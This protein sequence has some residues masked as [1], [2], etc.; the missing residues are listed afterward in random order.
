MERIAPHAPLGMVLFSSCLVLDGHP[1]Y[2]IAFPGNPVRR[3]RDDPSGFWTSFAAILQ[4]PCQTMTVVHIGSQCRDAALAH[5]ALTPA[6]QEASR[7]FGRG[8][9][10]IQ[11]PLQGQ[12]VVAVPGVGSVSRR[13]LGGL[14][15]GELL[16]QLS[17]EKVPR[18]RR[19]YTVILAEILAAPTQEIGSG[20]R[21][22][23]PSLPG[24][25]VAPRRHGRLRSSLQPLLMRQ[26]AVTV[27]E[28]PQLTFPCP[29]ACPGS[30]SGS[31]QAH[32]SLR[33]PTGPGA[34]GTARS[35]AASY[36]AAVALATGP[37]DSCVNMSV[38]SSLLR[39]GAVAE[40]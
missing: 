14:G 20:I 29:V 24:A 4:D 18:F 1:P 17:A 19:G 2:V 34:G 32:A 26:L 28:S 27:G 23:N 8:T 7:A 40:S 36:R 22:L 6:V 35:Q 15:Q 31:L 10:R 30:A 3:S 25:I 5:G 33:R 39:R 13:N 21:C 38:V 16:N 9:V 37:R 11:S 12:A